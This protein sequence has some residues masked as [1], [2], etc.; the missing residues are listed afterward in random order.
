MK[1]G[2][3]KADRK[4]FPTFELKLSASA[5]IKFAVESLSLVLM[6]SVKE[7]GFALALGLFCGYVFARQNIVALAPAFIASCVI[8]AL[9]WW[10][11]LFAA[12]P[13]IALFL[14]YFIYFKLKRNVPLWAVAL[15]AAIGSTPYVAVN[16]AI[17]GAY[18]HVAVALLIAV[19]AVFVAGIACYA[20]LVRGFSR[21]MSVE[22]CIA[23]GVA[24]AAF[25]YALSGADF[26]GFKLIFIA[27]GALIL[28]SSQCFKAQI[29]L[30]L[31]LLLGFG[32][33]L[34]MRDLA[35][36]AGLAV[37]GVAAVTF[38]PF[39]KWSS[40]LGMLA[41]QGAMWLAGAYA[42]AGWRALVMTAV[43]VVVCLCLPRR[44]I[45]R[46]KTM[47]D[48]DN[49]A[50]FTG[51]V[52]RQARNM[53]GRLYSAGEVFYELSKSMEKTVD[54]S[55]I[56][57][58][59]RLAHEVAR[60]YCGKCPDREGCFKPLGGEDTY[61][62][63]KPMAEAALNRGKVSVLDMPPFISSR[64]SKMHTLASVINGSAEAY[65][66]KRGECDGAML[67]KRMLS[68]QFAGV[69][70][71]LDSLAEECAKPV[72][73]AGGD[74]EYIKNELLKHNI[75]ASEGVISGADDELMLTLL[76]RAQ[77]AGK[78]ML[79]K[80]ASRALRRRLVTT[81]IEDRGED[82]LVFLEA[83]PTYEVAYG[84]ARRSVSENGVCGD[85][86]SVLC[87]SLRRRLFA[88][89]DGMGSGDDAAKASRDAVSMIES[90]YRA[91]FDG[92]IILSLINKLLGL[93]L[94][95]SFSSLDI[96]VI[97]AASGSMDVIKLGAASS[98]IVRRESIEQIS[99][100]QPPLGIVDGVQPLTS[101]YQLYDGDAVVMM[102][103]GVFDALEAKGIADIIESVGTINPQS[104]ADGLLAAAIKN[105]SKD[106][107]TALVMRLFAV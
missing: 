7:F 35:C 1:K 41:A 46:I 22:E 5:A 87:P 96:S 83:A 60:S 84:V 82:K 99:C 45:A 24:V 102:S 23:G 53:A 34:D 27:A 80:V 67:G 98:F 62:V 100:S 94:E 76:V 107:C 91:G 85:S 59:D 105:G 88:I 50:S 79:E 40:A 2:M 52:N 103:D 47:T 77:D 54:S 70:L 93:S 30:F 81:R 78:T 3:L 56:F 8:F 72:A 74:V 19:V 97:D 66:K 6:A 106:D 61:T 57:S 18:L 29:T 64:C 68:E 15:A 69:A 39:T 89:C 20:V 75:I 44:V 92:G 25:G 42:G 11:L 21:Y 43:G 90:F 36:L 14:L 104:L 65:V 26:W 48:A 95:D 12:T 38:S 86:N 33:A 49:R 51:I 4:Y 9:D 32:C 58:A 37:L 55:T 13:I 73:F 16:A 71:V 17:Y 101:R 28:L 31:A 63:L 10:T